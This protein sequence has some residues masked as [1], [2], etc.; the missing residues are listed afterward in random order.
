M[1]TLQER[2]V[3]LTLPQNR[4]EAPSSDT[5]EQRMSS[6]IRGKSHE[7]RAPCEAAARGSARA[8]RD[9]AIELELSADELLFHS[10]RCT[11]SRPVLAPARTA[12]DSPVL[13]GAVGVAHRRRWRLGAS[14]LALSLMM[15]ALIAGVA[16][17]QSSIL[18]LQ[19]RT[20]MNAHAERLP[21]APAFSAS[22]SKP[23]PVR[24]ANPFDAVEFFEFPPGTSREYAREAVAEFL[25]DR[26]RSRHARPIQRPRAH[27]ETRNS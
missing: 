7:E 26:A 18:T 8:E 4:D 9:S 25:L 19:T 10:P 23:L 16:R 12:E 11:V 13:P 6:T 5:R 22:A 24:F 2:A 17:H 21:T 3:S 27:R 1:R 20:A 14:A 15:A